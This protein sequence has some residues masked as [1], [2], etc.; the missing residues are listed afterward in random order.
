M[1]NG[2]TQSVHEAAGE[3]AKSCSSSFAATPNGTFETR[4][5]YEGGVL[6]RIEVDTDGDGLA[7]YARSYAGEWNETWDIDSDGIMDVERSRG[8]V[9]RLRSLAGIGEQERASP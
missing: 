9:R 4:E 7:E 3:F 5:L 6:A 2:T 8:L 1:E